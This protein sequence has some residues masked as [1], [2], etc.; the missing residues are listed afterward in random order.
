MHHKP[1]QSTARE[2]EHGVCLPQDGYF[3][4]HPAHS[5]VRGA[6]F[7]AQPMYANDSQQHW[8]G[9]ARI[10]RTLSGGTHGICGDFGY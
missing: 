7:L 2:C 10:A 9:R 3:E 8:M 1:E 4:K 5:S 6:E